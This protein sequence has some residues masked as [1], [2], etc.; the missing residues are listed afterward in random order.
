MG[1]PSMAGDGAD[2]SVNLWIQSPKLIEMRQHLQQWLILEEKR[3]K[4]YSK[5]DFHNKLTNFSHVSELD[6]ITNVI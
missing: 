1:S 3:C 5:E 6:A 2:P 4:R